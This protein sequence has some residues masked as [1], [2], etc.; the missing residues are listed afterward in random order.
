M[1]E[2]NNRL[3]TLMMIAAVLVFALQDGVSRHLGSHYNTFSI[4]ML[5]YWVF[6][7]FGY[8][9]VRRSLG[10][11]SAVWASPNKKWQI[12]RGVILAAEI[13]VMQVSFVN[14]GLI[15]THAVAALGGDWRRV[16]RCADRA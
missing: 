8:F 4:V 13:C 9:L 2:Q 16:H 15:E 7:I 14:L 1:T 11:F 5:R 3:G 10:G 6:L 12:V